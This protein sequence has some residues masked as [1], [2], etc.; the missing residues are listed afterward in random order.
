MPKNISNMIATTSENVVIIVIS[1]PIESNEFYKLY[2][3]IYQ[4]QGEY[5]NEI[6]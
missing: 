6:E 5:T 1:K 4:T 3:D 2:S